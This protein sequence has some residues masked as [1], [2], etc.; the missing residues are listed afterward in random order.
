[1]PGIARE[2][3]CGAIGSLSTAS[4]VA[5]I[6]LSTGLYVAN[7]ERSIAEQ[8]FLQVRQ[9][10]NKVFDID[11]A[12]RNTPGTTKAR[13]LI[14]STSL[15]YLQKVGAEARGD[16]DLALEIGSAYVQLA[17]VQG[18]PVNSNLGQFAAADE[19]LRKATSWWNP[20]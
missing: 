8:R 20:S 10:A 12:I 13:Q 5:V 16:R 11:V 15:E 18:V 19:S 3:L 1:M 2:S 17:H 9:L 14:V 4:A 7:R 6:G